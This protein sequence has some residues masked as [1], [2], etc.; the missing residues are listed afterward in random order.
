MSILVTLNVFS[1]FKNDSN[2][3]CKISSLIERKYNPNHKDIS[4][5]DLGKSLSFHNIRMRMYEDK[6]PLFLT[7][8]IDT[9]FLIE[10]YSIEDGEFKSRIWNTRDDINYSY[11][12]NK[13]DY[14]ENLFSN[15]MIS[16]VQNWDTTQ[17]K[18]EEITYSNM[19]PTNVICSTRVIK[20][21]NGYRIDIFS[22]KD[23]FKLGRDNIAN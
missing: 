23:F 3:F 17:L 2:N 9:L 5:H 6:H 16:L 20:L 19:N 12:F 22:F 10:K 1:S 8:Q 11:L 15:Y 4:T 7:G 14:T 18:K 21:K 13:I